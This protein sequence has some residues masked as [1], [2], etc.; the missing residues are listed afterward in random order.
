[1]TWLTYNNCEG[2]ISHIYIYIYIYIYVCVYY[3]ITGT[4]CAAGL[5]INHFVMLYFVK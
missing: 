5:L 4:L 1:M 2:G 3:K